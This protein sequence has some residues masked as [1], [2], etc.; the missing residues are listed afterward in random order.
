[1]QPGGRGVQAPA[2]TDTLSRVGGG[3]GR[4]GRGSAARVLWGSSGVD[5]VKLVVLLVLGAIVAS[6]GVALYHLSWGDGGSG[7]LLRS[8]TL[9]IGLSVALFVLL[10]L[11][12]RLG[13]IHPHGLQG[14]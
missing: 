12:W 1:V 5:P 3:R 4:A 11:A 13:Y 8:L 10:M 6:L 7:K 2:Y 14:Q 9:R